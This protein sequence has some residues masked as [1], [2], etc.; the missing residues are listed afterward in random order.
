MLEPP[1]INNTLLTSA[2]RDKHDLPVRRLEF[3]PL[4]ADVNTA[5][6]RVVSEDD[7]VYFL[8]LRRGTFGEMSVA[9]PKYL[10]DQGIPQ[11]IA[12]VP[13]RTGE[14]WASLEDFKL[15]LY[16]FI[17]GSDGYTVA[18]SEK[19]WL[20]FGTTLRRIHTLPTPASLEQGLPRETYSD[21]WRKVVKELLEKDDAGLDP[22]ASETVNF[23]KSKRTDILYL[24]KR[25]EELGLR[26]RSQNLALCVC[27][28]DLHAGNVLIANDGSFYLVDWDTL[29]FAPKERDLMF[30]GAGLLGEHLNPEEEA[31][32]FYQGYGKTD[33]NSFALAYFR[34][35][36]IIQ[37]VAAFAQELLSEQG[38]EESKKQSLCYLKGNFAPNGTVE[39]A[40][41]A[42]QSGTF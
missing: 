24:I 33:V 26:L 39:L 12:P 18:L 9:F 11:I 27:H 4:G 7:A 42:E 16:P 17:A 21:Q 8:K 36:R 2:L 28:A 34:Y 31:R 19:Q 29:L 14:L 23:L 37:D 1:K 20:E 5:V 40:R 35:E 15:I 13:T 6:Y 10:Y 41:H 25:T 30:I 3:L 22:V 38:G 32:L